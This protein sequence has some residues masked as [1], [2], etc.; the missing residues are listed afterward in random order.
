MQRTTFSEIFLEIVDQLILTTFP[1][2]EH[3][4]Y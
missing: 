1:D 3:M 2:I 4:P